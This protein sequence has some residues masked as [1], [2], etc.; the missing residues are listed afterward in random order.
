MNLGIV[1]RGFS[2]AHIPGRSAYTSISRSGWSLIPLTSALRAHTLWH[3]VY[4]P[5]CKVSGSWRGCGGQLE[6]TFN[7]QLSGVG[8]VSMPA[9][10]RKDNCPAGGWGVGE[11]LCNSPPHSVCILK[12]HYCY[13]L[14]LYRELL[15]LAEYCDF[16][17]TTSDFP[18]PL[19]AQCFT[20]DSGNSGFGISKQLH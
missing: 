17:Q 4:F 5:C 19:G 16:Q 13:S 8:S 11:G 15:T 2:A 1:A 6:S 3:H 14:R 9:L 7:H 20:C 10:R 12:F 18:P